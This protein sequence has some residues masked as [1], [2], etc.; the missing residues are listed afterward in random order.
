MSVPRAWR[1]YDSTMLRGEAIVPDIVMLSGSPAAP[2]RSEHLLCVAETMMSALGYGIQRIDI[3]RLPAAALLQ[4]D[5]EHP[6]VRSALDA[7]AAARGVVVAT[8][9]YNAA[10]SGVLKLFLDLLPRAAFSG[11]P[12]LPVATG[13]S[14]AHLLALDYAL[15]PVLAALGARLVLDNV[16]AAERDVARTDAGYEVTDALEQRLSAAV[17][18]LARAVDDTTM[19]ARMRVCVGVAAACAAN[20]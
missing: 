14:L 9:L 8:P 13:G 20:V 15:K 11:K 16:F 3:R 17:Q 6:I 4:C 5:R 1:Y 7:V 19:L 2:S 18:S 12:V 10:Y